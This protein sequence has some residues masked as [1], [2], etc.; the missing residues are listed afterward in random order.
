MTGKV[1]INDKVGEI[2]RLEGDRY[3]LK[4]RGMDE[5]IIVTEDL[6]VPTQKHVAIAT[7]IRQTQVKSNSEEPFQ[8]GTRCMKS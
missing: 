6:V 7:V 8:N 2:V 4:V 1:E 3:I 5:V